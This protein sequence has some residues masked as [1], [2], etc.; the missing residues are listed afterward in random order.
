MA[1]AFLLPNGNVFKPLD[2]FFLFAYNKNVIAY[3]ERNIVMAK[4]P[5][6]SIQK[7]EDWYIAT[8]LNSGVTSQGKTEEECTANL[9]EAVALYY[10]GQP[11]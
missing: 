1:S 6:I 9:K 3:T 10:D 4:E 7:E 5:N 11:D 8:D 2:L